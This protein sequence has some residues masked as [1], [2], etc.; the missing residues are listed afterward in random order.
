MGCGY[1]ISQSVNNEIIE[2]NRLNTLDQYR[3]ENRDQ[4]RNE[5][6]DQYR[7]ENRNRNYKISK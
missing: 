7:N 2:S 4:Y 6:R 3:D 5:N 1:S